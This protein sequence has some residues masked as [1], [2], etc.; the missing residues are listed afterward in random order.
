MDAASAVVTISLSREADGRAVASPYRAE[1]P[2]EP[3]EDGSSVVVGVVLV[4][5]DASLGVGRACVFD[6]LARDAEG[7]RAGAAVHVELEWWGVLH[8]TGAGT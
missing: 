7:N 5:E 4:V 3:V 6:A 1:L 8:K 2:F